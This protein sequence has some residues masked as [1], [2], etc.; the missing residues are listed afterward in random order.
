LYAHTTMRTQRDDPSETFDFQMVNQ[1]CPIDRNHYD[2][3]RPAPPDDGLTLRCTECTSQLVT[4]NIMGERT[5]VGT[6][7]ENFYW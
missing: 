4:E 7:R 6:T 2:R 3:E 1:Y 5:E